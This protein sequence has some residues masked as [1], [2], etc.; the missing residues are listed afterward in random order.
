MAKGSDAP[1]IVI[2]R[3]K[4]GG[5]GHHGGSWKVAFADF[6]TAMMAFFLLMWLMGSTSEEQKG[7]ISE[8]FNN[9]SAVPG[10]STM[11]SP[12][13]INGP[14]GASI[15]MITLGGGMELHRTATEE[16]ASADP[17]APINAD[18]AEKLA[19]ELDKE[20]LEG[21]MTELREA[22]DQRES[23]AKFKD[24][25]LLDVTPE[26]VR[27]QIID[28]ERRSMFPLGSPTLEPF[29]DTILRE[30]ATVIDNVP[31]RISI[32]GHTDIRPY[33]RL[34]YSNWELSADRANAARRSLLGGGL[35]E[36]RIGRVVGLASSVLLDPQAPDSPIN[37]R[38]SIVVMNKRTEDA[39][40]HENGSLLSV[41]DNG[42]GA[43]T[44]GEPVA[45][46]SPVQN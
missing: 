5:H 30:L 7:A 19:E 8:Y 25:I 22:I 39:I 37:R 42:A 38:I 40:N 32:S 31:N 18:T 16:S 35:T 6:A 23:L 14:G 46:L 44:S 9:P 20:R 29:A 10:S 11:P 1:T 34:N 45:A 2:K 13:S 43:A 41:Q 15:S 24:Q 33:G 21:L 3:V 27:I 12:T 36:A 26:G 4:K 17:A 28:H